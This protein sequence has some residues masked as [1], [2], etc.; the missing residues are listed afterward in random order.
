MVRRKGSR[1]SQV[2][3]SKEFGGLYKA[4]GSTPIDAFYNILNK[5]YYSTDYHGHRGET[6][7]TDKHGKSVSEHFFMTHGGDFETDYY[8]VEDPDPYVV[9]GSVTKKGKR[10]VATATISPV[11][12]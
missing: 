3:K 8:F 7:F 2:I 10:W 5:I 4:S 9:Y 11:E 6:E 12:V 1:R